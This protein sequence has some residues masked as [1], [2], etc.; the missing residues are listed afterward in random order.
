MILRI[1]AKSLNKTLY[2][3]G[4][5]RKGQTMTVVLKAHREKLIGKGK[6]N[7][8][9]NSNP[10]RIDSNSFLYQDRRSESNKVQESH[11]KNRSIERKRAKPL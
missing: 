6:L 11:V 1:K 2:S 4:T 10:Q 9:S 3:T 8:S 7:I 5:L